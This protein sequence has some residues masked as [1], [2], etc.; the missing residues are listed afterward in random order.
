MK[1]S[2]VSRRIESC[3]KFANIKDYESALIHFFPALVP[4]LDKTAKKRR[5]KEGVG[6]RIRKFIA[7]QE[8]IISA[9]DIYISL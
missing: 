5:P 7:D 8:G 2:S 9:I 3:I 4:A 6:S 1:P